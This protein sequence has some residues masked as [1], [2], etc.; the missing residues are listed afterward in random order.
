MFGVIGAAF[1]GVL[2]AAVNVV[3]SSTTTFD[4]DFDPTQMFTYANVI[5]NS[6]MPLVYITAGFGLGFTIIYSLKNAFGSRM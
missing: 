2:G 6:M 1:N 5:T 4:L 3:A